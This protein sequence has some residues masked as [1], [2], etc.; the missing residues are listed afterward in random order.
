[1]VLDHA[2]VRCVC[3]LK[4]LE[5][6]CCRAGADHDN[7]FQF[8]L[9]GYGRKGQIYLHDERYVPG[10]SLTNDRQSLLWSRHR[11]SEDEL[12]SA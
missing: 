1:M 10:G 6:Q 8:K 11:N 4:R 3:K 7:D 5:E 12:K 2:D 9:K